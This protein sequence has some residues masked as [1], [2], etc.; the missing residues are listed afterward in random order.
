MEPALVVPTELDWLEILARFAC[1]ALLPLAI[2][3]ERFLR[4]KPIDFR[5]FIIISVASC[6]MAIAGLQLALR[7]TD[8]QLSVDPTR[9]FAGVITGVGFLGA[10]AVFREGNHVVGSGSAAAIWAAGVIGTLSGAGMLWLAGIVG[11]FVFVV[12]LVS[13]PLVYGSSSAGRAADEPDNSS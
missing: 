5:P 3:T 8:P 12:L 9:I 7:G 13:D 10:G 1:A 11:V 6:G 4:K 2:G